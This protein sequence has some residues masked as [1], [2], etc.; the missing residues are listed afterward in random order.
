MSEQNEKKKQMVYPI[1]I[2]TRKVETLKTDEDGNSIVIDFQPK[3][4]LEYIVSFVNPSDGQ[5]TSET[6]KTYQIAGVLRTAIKEGQNEVEFMA[7]EIEYLSKK[8]DK[9][10]WGT[11]NEGTVQVIEEIQRLAE[12]AKED[13]K[14]RGKE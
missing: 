3:D 13:K 8:L 10:R 7:D 9:I 6:L 5:S 4:I 14:N 1:S 2:E 12:K 11:P